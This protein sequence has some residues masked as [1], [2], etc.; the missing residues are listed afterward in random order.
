MK[1]TTL[2]VLLLFMSVILGCVQTTGT[3]PTGPDGSG[4]LDDKNLTAQFYY[5]K[6]RHLANKGNLV[7]AEAALNAAVEKD[8]S[9]SFLKREMIRNLHKQKKADQA[10]AMAEALVDQD[11]DNVDNLLILVRLKKGDEYDDALSDIGF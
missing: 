4:A 5:L 2:C 6:A 1:N 7:Q 8:P 11:P 9:S 10:L 3:S